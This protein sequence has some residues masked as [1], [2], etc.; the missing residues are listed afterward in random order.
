MHPRSRPNLSS[1]IPNVIYGI[2]SKI[3]LPKKYTIERQR[4][5]QLCKYTLMYLIYSE[6]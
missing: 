3:G 6:S 2:E 1:I 4:G 5:I